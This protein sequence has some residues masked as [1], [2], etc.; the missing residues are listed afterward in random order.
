MILVVLERSPY[1]ARRDSCP[2]QEN[3]SNTI[4]TGGAAGAATQPNC[5][6]MS[7]LLEAVACGMEGTNH[8]RS[9]V[10][11]DLSAP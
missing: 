7:F 9:L 6:W 10:V 5:W 1:C 2:A 8:S 11:L 3:L 4:L